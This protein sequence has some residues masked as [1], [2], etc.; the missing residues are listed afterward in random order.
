[1]L[2]CTRLRARSRDSLKVYENPCGSS[3][4]DLSAEGAKDERLQSCKAIPYLVWV[5]GCPSRVYDLDD[6]DLLLLV[7]SIEEIAGWG[8]VSIRAAT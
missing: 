8:D 6:P 1:M 2:K 5:S 3:I 4:D 7:L